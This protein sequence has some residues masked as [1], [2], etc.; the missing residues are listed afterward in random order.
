MSGVQLPELFDTFAPNAGVL[1]VD[2]V[3][4]DCREDLAER[5]DRA[6]RFEDCAYPLANGLL[7]VADL[8]IVDANQLCTF[9][10]SCRSSVPC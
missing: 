8:R 7:T 9:A 2:A 5:V 1:V 6:D 10:L 3:V 4:E